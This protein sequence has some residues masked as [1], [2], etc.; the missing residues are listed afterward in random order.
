M[1][2]KTTIILLVIAVL[3]GGFV[4]YDHTHLKDTWE[5]EQQQKRVFP[6]LKSGD[7]TKLELHST[8]GVIVV[9]KAGDKWDMKQPYQVRA[10][11][12]MV[13]AILSDLEF[14][15]AERA[16]TAKDLKEAN[17]TPA[18]YGLEK[19][20]IEATITVSGK[21]QT[22]KLGDESKVG[23]NVY[24]AIAGSDKVYVV[25]KRMVESLSKTVDDMRDRS[26][27]EFTASQVNKMKLKAGNRQVELSKIENTAE[28]AE[29]WR[30][31]R[32]I[33]A[34]ADR[35]KVEGIGSK[36]ADLKVETFVT[37]DPK[38]L[39][40]YGLDEPVQEVSLF[41]KGSDGGKTVQFGAALTNDAT[42]VY[43]KRESANSVFTVKSDILTN[44]VAQVNEL[45]DRSLAEFETD[46]VKA[47]DLLMSGLNIKLAHDTNGWAIVEPAKLKAEQSACDDLVHHIHDAEIKE[48][49]ADVITDPAQFG[50]D[51]PACEITLKKEKPPPAAVTSTNEPPKIASATNSVPAADAKTPEWVSLV[52]LQIGKT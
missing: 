34:R 35:T 13:D 26:V 51:K 5:V 21:T 10:N 38:D 4:W 41:V 29:S 22:I 14:L 45:R 11:K 31:L 2:P 42:K 8:N 37:E 20:R 46:Q 47:V 15:D 1:K 30:I 28:S 44:L 9:E 18:G 52:T 43:A 36:L 3:I 6:N 32:P 39:K 7:V 40:P 19:P 27:L 12:S 50:L 23:G 25:P 48:F 16:M 24:A 17:E 49:A 33:N